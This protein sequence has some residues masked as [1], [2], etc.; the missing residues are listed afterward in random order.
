MKS[1]NEQ[2]RGQRQKDLIKRLVKFKGLSKKIKGKLQFHR[3]VENNSKNKRIK[4]FHKR[5]NN[6]INYLFYETQAI[7]KR[8]RT[9]Y[10]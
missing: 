9:K 8:T 5:I 1:R 3:K 4:P 10:N 2:I 6:R 7:Q